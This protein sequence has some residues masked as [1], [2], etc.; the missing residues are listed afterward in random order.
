[1][2]A[3]RITPSTENRFTRQSWWR[4]FRPVPLT[5][6]RTI[7]NRPKIVTLSSPSE[8]RGALPMTQL[9]ICGLNASLCNRTTGARATS[10]SIA[11]TSNRQGHSFAR[12][13]C[14][15]SLAV[16]ATN[17]CFSGATLNSGSAANPLRNVRVRRTSTNASVAPSYPIMSISPFTRRGI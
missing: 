14:R 16:R 3:S 17:S 13:S 8:S 1:V 2:D 10:L 6:S 9:Y 12:S 4:V 15:K 7:T 11:T 5:C